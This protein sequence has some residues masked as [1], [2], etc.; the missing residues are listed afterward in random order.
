LIRISV[1]IAACCVIF[2][3]KTGYCL[4]PDEIMVVT[5]G[6]C[7]NS[8]A[9]GEYYC[10]RR[11]VDLN[12][13]LKLQLAQDIG[14]QISRRDYEAKI[15]EPVRQKLNTAQW[16][17]AIRCL[18]TVY[19]VPTKVGPRGKLRGLDDEL[20]KLKKWLAQNQVAGEIIG[21]G[22]AD[23]AAQQAENVKIAGVRSRIDTIE[24]R[25]TD[26]SLDSELSMVLFDDYELYRWQPNALKVGSLWTKSRTLMVSR[27]DGPGPDIAR[28]LVDKAIN[29]EEKGLK[30]KAY[31]DSRGLGREEAAIFRH[32]DNSLANLATILKFRTNMEV[33]HEDTAKLFQP[34]ECPDTAIYCGWYSLKNYVDAFDFAEGAVGYHIASWEAVDLRNAQ[35]SQWCPAML[36]DGITV[37]MGA[38][39]EPYLR[40]FPEPEDF[41]SKLL[42]GQCVVEAYY[43]SKPFN[44]WQLL[45]IGDP[46]YRPFARDGR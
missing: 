6:N 24:G 18:V 43:H 19:G 38:V 17:Q 41:F 39:S 40:A 42:Q 23:S 30:G 32:F 34:G 33:C 45:L 25:E 13:I 14:C 36:K 20:Q 12:H 15:A 28:G 22:T 27:L 9:V 44:S 2:G 37:T 5:N 31:I 26:A 1:L 10:S 29:A 3:V 35:S 8:V 4:S 16:G 11:G 46:L 7:G 21:D